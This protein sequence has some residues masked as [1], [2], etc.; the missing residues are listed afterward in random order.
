MFIANLF[1]MAKLRHQPRC[2]PTGNWIKKMWYIYTVEYYP[3]IKTEIMSFVGTRY[4]Y[5]KKNKPNSEG[6]LPDFSLP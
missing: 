2:P 5:A 3:V 1:T 4:H 6:Q